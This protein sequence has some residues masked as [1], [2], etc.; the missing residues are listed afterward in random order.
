MP[1]LQDFGLDKGL[2]PNQRSI[3]AADTV[4]NA[5]RTATNDAANAAG[6]ANLQNQQAAL[7]EAIAKGTDAQ[8]NPYNSSLLATMQ[9]DLLG[10]QI[11]TGT[12]GGGAGVYAGDQSDVE[13]ARNLLANRDVATPAITAT[14]PRGQELQKNAA[15]RGEARQSAQLQTP[16]PIDLA[17]IDAKYKAVTDAGGSIDP[18]KVLDEKT[19]AMKYNA[20]I[21]ES[22]QKEDEAAKLQAESTAKRGAASAA[23]AAESAGATR[24][25]QTGSAF[26]A[27]IA[28]SPPEM[29]GYLQSAKAYADSLGA[30][31]E[32]MTYDEFGNLQS[33]KAMEKPF[34][35]VQKILD[36]HAAF[37]K[38]SVEKQQTFMDEQLDRTTK[39]NAQSQENIL[40]QLTWQQSK[41]ERD[42]TDF[43][44]KELD[45]MTVSL[46]LRGGYGS[47]DG[48]REVAE[49][50]R[51]SWI[52][53]RN[54]VSRRPILCSRSRN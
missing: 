17:S 20:V 25:A 24:K 36:D 7:S 29:Q 9:S 32:E 16:Q 13:A 45:R 10:S 22:Q 44:K 34:D 15:A 42:Q 33:T 43:N 21:Q 23:S 30:E 41:L 39:F 38:G 8:G 11:R 27:L 28:S 54:S 47:D 6:L 14:T 31:E 50:R 48:N 46:A 40:N 49:A 5:G 18:A 26:D 37:V 51:R 1:T 4:A 35:A 12:Y 19:A 2:V 53:K 3:R 52:Y